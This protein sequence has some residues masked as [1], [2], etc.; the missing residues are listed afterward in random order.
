MKI[1]TRFLVMD[2]NKV[3]NA[4]GY[5]INEILKIANEILSVV[6]GQ[7]MI[8]NPDDDTIKQ[9]PLKDVLDKFNPIY[10]NKKVMSALKDLVGTG[11][12]ALGNM[13]E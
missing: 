12:I 2:G 8:D 6:G 9:F 11:K 3:M 5:E 4:D 1:G 10:G 13:G 7:D